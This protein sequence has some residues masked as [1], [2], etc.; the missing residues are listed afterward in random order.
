MWTDSILII[1]V[2]VSAIGQSSAGLKVQAS[3]EDRESD[4]PP[5]TWSYPDRLRMD[6]ENPRRARLI[7]NGQ[8]NS[9]GA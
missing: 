6:A 8:S 9:H 3:W 2:F 4:P 5:P 7:R 1:P